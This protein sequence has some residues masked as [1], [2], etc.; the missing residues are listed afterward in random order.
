MFLHIRLQLAQPTGLCDP[1]PPAPDTGSCPYR[2]TSHSLPSSLPCLCM[3]MAPGGAHTLPASACKDHPRS[4]VGPIPPLSRTTHP[5]PLANSNGRFRGSPFSDPP[6]GAVPGYARPV[7]TPANTGQAPLALNG[8][9]PP[10]PPRPLPC[11][12]TYLLLQSSHPGPYP[13]T[14]RSGSLRVPCA[15]WRPA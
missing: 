11:L 13:L 4:P 10:P 6:P 3:D 7:C 5:P 15:P 12:R 8:L 14:L 9:P 2:S 1:R